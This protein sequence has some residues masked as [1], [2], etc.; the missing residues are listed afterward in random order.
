MNSTRPVRLPS[1]LVPPPLRAD[2]LGPDSPSGSRRILHNPIVRAVLLVVL[3][4]A[5]MQL[6]A[7][8]PTLAGWPGASVIIF[9]VAGAVLAYSFMAR[10]IEGRRTPFEIAPTRWTGL[11]WG[12]GLGFGL[13]TACFG[14]LLL[15]G[16]YRITGT[17]TA[18]PWLMPALTLGLWAGVVEEIISRAG[19]HRL[20]EQG[21]GTWAAAVLSGAVFGMAHVTNPAGTLWGGLAITLQAGLSYGLL[22]SLTRSLWVVVGLHA[23]WNLT[24][25][26]L[27]G[28][29]VSGTGDSGS[30]LL[31]SEAMGP[32]RLSGG[33]FG[34]EASPV[35]VLVMLVFSAALAVL[36]VRR[37]LVVAPIWVRRRR[38]RAHPLDRTSGS[39]V[40]DRRA[41]TAESAAAHPR[42][43]TE[44]ENQATA[45]MVAKA[46]P[47]MMPIS[48]HRPR[49]QR[50]RRAGVAA[51]SALPVITSSRFHH[52]S[53]RHTAG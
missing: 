1:S 31:V 39:G 18:G 20:L 24:Q 14:I 21:F 5:G 7:A 37:G 35:T 29:I 30:G 38:L 53:P 41:A 19:L 49:E 22:Y 52:G 26:L 4:V 50:G 36:L 43:A 27:F 45:S 15:T 13:F 42:A 3:L 16:V 51:A 28:A 33:A 48:P 17:D 32:D 44:P 8:V 9:V 46:M 34:P 2:G 11:L 40:I 6:F 12:L 10:V 47:Q 23:A 25:G